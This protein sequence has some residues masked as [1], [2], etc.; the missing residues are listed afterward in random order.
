[1]NYEQLQLFHLPPQ[2][3]TIHDPYWDEL[4]TQTGDILDSA[5]LTIAIEDEILDT[6]D[7]V[8]PQQN[9]RVGAQ[10]SFDESP[11]KSVGAQVN[12]DTKKSAP[13]HDVKLHSRDT[14]ATH[15]VEKYWV[16]RVGNKYWYYRYCWME[17]RKKNRIYIGAVRNSKANLKK[18]AVEDAINNGELSTEIIQ[19]LKSWKTWR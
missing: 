19:L 14:E 12:N 7:C 3:K 17:G 1:M 8:A 13:Q 6:G 9:N 15:W 10:T 18:Q 11:Y 16:E 5:H 4:E 2:I